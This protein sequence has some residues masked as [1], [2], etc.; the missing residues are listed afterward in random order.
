MSA[1]D[2]TARFPGLSRLAP[3]I[4]DRL[5]AAGRAESF[6]PGQTIFSP[7]HPHQGLLFLTDGTIRVFQTSE[8]GREIVLYRVEA[9]QSCVLTNACLLAHED[10]AAEGVAETAVS[11]IALPEAAFDALM[12]ECP[13]FR[14][15]IFTAYAQRMNDLFHVIDEV[16]FGRIDIRLAARLLAL[17]H[18]A[19]EI[20][21][22]HQ[23]LATE[24]G[25]AREVISR[26][27][28]DFHKRGLVEQGRGI[29]TLKDVT[30]LE[31]LSHSES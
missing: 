10:N 12:A 30:A 22:T 11:A 5:H 25:T 31:R 18:G 20:R 17:A 6:A 28:N 29:I 13:P 1:P 26:Q 7:A 8:S 23:N 19:G 27:L 9:G 16:A 15:F 24:L 3:D 14:R 4:R 2:W 21:V